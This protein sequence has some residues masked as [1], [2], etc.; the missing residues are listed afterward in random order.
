MPSALNARAQS[1]AQGLDASPRAQ[2]GT[3]NSPWYPSL[4]AFEHYN[5]GRSH[6]FPKARFGGSV[7]GRNTVDLVWSRKGAYP[8]GYNMS[9]LNAKAAFI[10]GGS[11]GDVRGSIGPFVAKVNPTTLKPVWYT[12]LVNTV[13]TSEWDYPGAM[14]IENNGY[15]YVVSGYRIFKV[16]AASGTVV[17]TLELPTMVYMRNNYPNTPPTY[18]TTPTQDAV[19][20]SYNGINALP[21]GTIV[22]KSLYREAGCTWNG[23]SALLKCGHA[24]DVP[25]SLL[26]SVN[27]NTMRII[28]KVTLRAPAGARPTITRYHGV[29]YVYLL[30]STS[31]A[32][33]YSVH[34][35]VFTLDN[36]WTPGAV[37]YSGQ[38]TGGSL[39]IMNNWIVGATNAIPAAG[40]LTVFAINQSDARKVIYKQPYLN[41]PLS[42]LL[43]HV[44]QTAAA[45]GAQAISWAD[46]SLEADPQNGLFYGVETLARKVAAFKLTPPTIKVVWKKTE[47]TTEWATLVGRKAHRVWVG[48]DIPRAQLP[49]ANKTDTVVF[50]D[51]ATGRELARSAQV[52]HMTQGSAV[53]PGYGGSVFFPGAEGTLVKMTP[54]PAR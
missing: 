44:F 22:V 30:E 47:T 24:Q 9:Y 50:R 1:P 27:P 16:N 35:G 37:P 48:T 18:D 36:S 19:N 3:N 5:S 12:Q 32:V 38:T 6:V 39:I 51:A 13:E 54:R 40:A 8:S 4:E 42:P 31:N 23:P 10:Q 33:R 26:V 11:Y 52:P 28:D 29:D 45:G 20:T 17:K 43:R 49:G 2:P 21:D 7:D 53:Q 15:I 34:H 14:A 41:D 25:Q 46:M